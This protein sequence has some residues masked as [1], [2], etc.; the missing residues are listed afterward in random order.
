MNKRRCLPILVIAIIAAVMVLPQM[1]TGGLILENDS[2]FHFNRIFDTYAQLKTHRLSYFQMNNSFQQ[3]GRVINAVYRPGLSYILGFLLLICGSWV[4]FQVAS[5]FLVFFIA[6]IGMYFLSKRIGADTM[7]AICASAIF[8]GSPYIN[9]WGL[10]QQFTSWGMMLMPFVFVNGLDMI[11]VNKEV[12]VVSLAVSVAVVIQVHMLSA[13]LAVLALIP[14]FL[15]GL[16]YRTERINYCL[17]VGIA[18]AIALV[19]SLNVFGMM[20]ELFTGNNI[21]PPF[22]NMKMQDYTGT[23]SL[24]VPPITAVNIGVILSVILV[25]YVIVFMILPKNRIITTVTI[26]SVLFFILSSKLVPW[27]RLSTLIPSVTT[28]IQFPI[29]F[30]T[31]AETLMVA[32]LSYEFT[33][34]KNK[35]NVVSSFASAF[36]TACAICAVLV[37]SGQIY[38]ES[39]AWYSNSPIQRTVNLNLAHKASAKDIRRAF[40][41]SDLSAGLNLVQKESPDYLPASKKM[42]AETYEHVHPYFQYR[43]EFINRN[44]MFNKRIS[45]K[46]LITRWRQNSNGETTVPVV[47][48]KNTKVILNGRTLNNAD[49]RT[50]V[51]GSMMLKSKKGLNTLVTSYNP[52]FLTKF[53]IL[54]AVV[55]WIGLIFISLIG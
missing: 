27:T 40:A 3:S 12:N 8:M 31:V 18:S 6:G 19:L 53:A 22:P 51:I 29:R 1:I 13:V 52:N 55:S 44:W 16:W 7:V 37:C 41:S 46:R 2:I 9:A 45:G 25:V 14:F 36:V 26:I 50:S 4:N 20:G 15:I 30:L 48:Y 24:N 54:A 5:L 43:Q 17:R 39:A 49:V 10:S 23:L 34:L 11:D 38:Q 33:V 47:K 28:F 32:G 35:Q 21:I 42:N